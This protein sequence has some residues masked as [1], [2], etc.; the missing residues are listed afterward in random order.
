MPES[1]TPESTD[2]LLDESKLEQ[3]LG[4]KDQPAT[5]VFVTGVMSRVHRQRRQRRLILGLS[6]VVGAGFGLLGASLLSQ[7]IHQFFSSLFS[8]DLLM[9]GAVAIS[10]CAALM[11]L[12][13][14][15]DMASMS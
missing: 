15:D 2:P 4:Y 3:L 6:G 12:L 5:D 7:P 10:A 8:G 13:F 14:L 9:A 11:G 1:R